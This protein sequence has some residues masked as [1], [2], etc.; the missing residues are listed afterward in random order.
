MTA[1]HLVLGLS[2]DPVHIGH[3]QMVVQGVRALRARAVDVAS[4]LLIPVYRRNPVG[5]A[6]TRLPD[7]FPQR[8]T[9][10]R[11]VALEMSRALDAPPGFVRASGIEAELA[12]GRTQPNLTVETLRM[13]KLRLAPR[14]GLLFLV[15]SELVSGPSPEL[16]HW[17]RPDRLLRLARL[18]VCPR[19][20]YPLRGSFFRAAAQPRSSVIVLPE[21]RTAAVA[22]TDLRAWL[23][24]GIS[25]LALAHQQL[26]PV[27]VA[28]YLTKRGLT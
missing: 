9:M 20:G 2:A 22:S 27:S 21:V 5:V 4:V 26:L 14:T 1:Y 3:V 25:P 28:R 12:R 24:K 13:L 6:K 16:A 15:S 23:E 18:V 7:T 19:P 8:L 10:C 11:L 17:H